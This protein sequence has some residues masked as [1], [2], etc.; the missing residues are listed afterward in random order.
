M[1][2]RILIVEDNMNTLKVLSAIL[3]DEGFDVTMASGSN[4]ALEIFRNEDAFDAI[5]A[6]LKM[7]GMDGVEL[8]KE[9]RTLDEGIPFI[10]MT[11]YGTIESAVKA[12][13]EGVSNYLMLSPLLYNFI[14]IPICSL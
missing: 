1:G 12:M 2:Y 7:P 6:D 11:A 14:P 5:L 10:I 13:K 8:F 9:V 4:K 3:E